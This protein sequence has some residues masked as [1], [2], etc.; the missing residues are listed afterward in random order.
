MI[1]HRIRLSEKEAACLLRA[2]A[3]YDCLSTVGEST[4]PMPDGAVL[5]VLKNDLIE[6]LGDCLTEKLAIVG[7]TDDY[8]LTEEGVMLE[9]LI[10][11]LPKL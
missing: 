2:I 10:D 9:S 3:G 8:S 6:R 4:T 7:F 5:V 11:R 1:Q